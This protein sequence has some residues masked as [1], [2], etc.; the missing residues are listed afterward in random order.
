MTNA[1]LD[2]SLTNQQ[3]YSEAVHIIM[4]A[5]CNCGADAAVKHGDL[6]YCAPCWMD[7]YGPAKHHIK[8]T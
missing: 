1:K 8:T 5:Q 2:K 6:I 7:E 3:R 4:T